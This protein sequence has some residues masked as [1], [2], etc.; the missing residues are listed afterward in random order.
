LHDDGWLDE[1]FHATLEGEQVQVVVVQPDGRILLGGSFT[2]VNGV[3]RNGIARL[4][5]DGSLD[6]TFDP[7]TGVTSGFDG[8]EPAP[9]FVNTL[10]LLT[11]G[12]IAIGGRF[13]A[14]NGTAR[15]GLACLTAF[16]TL[17]ATFGQGQ[18]LA[19]ESGDEA[20]VSALAVQPDG[21]VLVGGCFT[22]ADGVPRTNLVRLQTDGAVD[23]S[24]DAPPFGCFDRFFELAPPVSAIVVQ[25]DGRV[26]IGGRLCGQ[27][28]CANLLRLNADGTLDDT[29]ESVARSLPAFGGFLFVSFSEVRAVAVQ[30]DGQVLIGGNFREIDGVSV[31]SLAR[32]NGGVGRFE[33]H[34]ATR[35]GGGR[36]QL[37]FAMPRG[38]DHLLDASSNLVNWIGLNQGRALRDQTQF[39]D[40]GAAGADRR[41]YRARKIP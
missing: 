28:D 30:P 12:R 41:F 33:F 40:P 9:G 8:D 10:A 37:N 3:P 34:S 20:F 36:V 7:G 21:R 29:F 2:K 11:G 31:P 5:S 19:N 25:P 1:S 18:G 26:L 17:D 15:I 22:H 35:I 27:S 32:L 38:Q 4:N 23:L 13:S 14:V 39:T 24:F 16:G 6:G